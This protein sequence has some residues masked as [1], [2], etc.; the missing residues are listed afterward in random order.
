MAG[1]R[2][3]LPPVVGLGKG[4]A[5]TGAGK[6]G[7]SGGGFLGV[8]G[9]GGGFTPGAAP[10]GVVVAGCSSV[11]GSLFGGRAMVSTLG[12]G[13]PGPSLVGPATI[14]EGRLGCVGPE[15]GVVAPPVVGASGAFFATACLAF[16]TV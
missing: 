16:G 11:S 7:G 6:G 15:A 8:V 2:A 12:A 1:G 13:T 10:G 9:A 4:V 3:A 14:P 5:E